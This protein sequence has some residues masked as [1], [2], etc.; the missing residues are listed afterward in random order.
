MSNKIIEAVKTLDY[1][2]LAT[3]ALWTFLQAFLAVLLFSSDSIIDL[4]FN[5]DWTGLY[6]LIIATG[7]AGIAAGLS[8]LKTLLLSVVSEIKTKAK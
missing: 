6:A 4:L 8:A 5:G 3:R 7:V 1:K 2:D